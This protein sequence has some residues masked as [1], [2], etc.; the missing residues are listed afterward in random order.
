MHINLVKPKLQLFQQNCSVALLKGTCLRKHHSD[1]VKEKDRE[2]K[3]SILRYLNPRTL[4]HKQS[5]FQELGPH[6]DNED[7]KTS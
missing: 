1:A 5:Y 7:A 6:R 3:K 2:E 4:V